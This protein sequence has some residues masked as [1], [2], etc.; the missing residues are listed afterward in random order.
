MF[1]GIGILGFGIISFM[2]NIMMSG[3][4][5]PSALLSAKLG[6][7]AS[8]LFCLSGILGLF[9]YSDIPLYL[10]NISLGFAFLLQISAFTLPK[11]FIN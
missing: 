8:F 4:G 5:T 7:S 3:S 10:A 2:P 11:Y 6:M 1:Y 9:N